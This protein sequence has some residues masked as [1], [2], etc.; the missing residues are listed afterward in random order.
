M[1][2]EF[3]VKKSFFN[4]YP[5]VKKKEAIDLLS[6]MLIFNPFKRY[7][8]KGCLMH[9]YFDGIREQDI[10]I[11]EMESNKEF[12]WGF[13]D[14]ELN[15]ELIQ[16]LIYKESLQFH[17]DDEKDG[18][19]EKDEKVQKEKEE[20]KENQDKENLILDKEIV[21]KSEITLKEHI[22][23]ADPKIKAA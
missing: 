16:K 11:N 14:I 15:K 2:M 19:D 18:K 21:K 7:D 8:V 6:K 5:F 20:N 23:T 1:K 3:K 17:P 4:M 12:D 9:P 13:D 10:D 22:P